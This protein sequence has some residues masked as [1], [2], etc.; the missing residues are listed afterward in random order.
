MNE[1]LLL[2]LVIGVLVYVAFFN[3]PKNVAVQQNTTANPVYGNQQTSPQNEFDQIL[4]LIQSGINAVSNVAN[5]AATG[6]QRN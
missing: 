1:T 6:A 3:K 5:A 2:Y 4:G